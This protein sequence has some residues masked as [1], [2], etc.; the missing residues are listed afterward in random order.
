MYKE[1]IQKLQL[2]MQDFRNALTSENYE[3]TVS[4]MQ[5][6]DK[7]IKAAKVAELLGNVNAKQRRTRE[8]AAACW[9]CEQPTEDITTNNGDFHK[10]KVKKY[11]KLAELKWVDAKFENGVLYELSTNGENFKMY[12]KKYNG[13]ETPTYIRPASFAEFLQLNYI[14][15]EDIT[16]EQFT[17]I[18]N[19]IKEANEEIRKQIEAYGKKMDSLKA[20]SLKCW[21]LVSQ[22][23]EHVYLY[24]TLV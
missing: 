16:T 11:P 23:P 2:E 19:T 12:D 9:E 5:V 7:Q 4:K 3:E 22:R 17:D 10:V 14:S 6:I 8:A 1:T 18:S 21:G 15:P 24:S 13:N 20:Y